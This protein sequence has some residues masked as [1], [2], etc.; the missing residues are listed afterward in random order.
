MQKLA[1]SNV[2]Q[3]IFSSDEIVKIANSNKNK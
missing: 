1:E 3:S 2:Y